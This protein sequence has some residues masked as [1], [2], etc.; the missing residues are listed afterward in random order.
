MDLAQFNKLRARS[1]NEQKSLLKKI[2]KGQTVLCSKCDQVIQ[3]NVAVKEGEKAYA[4]C[5][6]GCTYIELDMA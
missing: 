3:L 6:K 1:F 4:K 5:Q 2:A